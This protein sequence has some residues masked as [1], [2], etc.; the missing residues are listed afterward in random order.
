M[1]RPAG[2]LA[3]DHAI[4]SGAP[5]MHRYVIERDLPGIGGVPTEALRQAARSCFTAASDLGP[6]IQWVRSH[7]T[8]NRIYCEFFAESEALVRE[9]ARR[10]GLPANRVSEVR[11]VL[12]PLS[13]AP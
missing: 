3:S 1:M 7:V 11:Q 4:A 5:S 10:A 8:D 12:D 6:G 13:A 2:T 9:H